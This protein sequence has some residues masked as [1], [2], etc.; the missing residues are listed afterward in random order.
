MNI[1][2]RDGDLII[3]NHPNAG[4]DP[5]QKK[6]RELLTIDSIYTVERTEVDSW[7]TNVY[8]KEFPGE[9]FNSVLF[10]DVLP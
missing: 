7:H 6:A 1:Y 5:D 9:V 4:Y 10:D 2:A 3:F 8:L